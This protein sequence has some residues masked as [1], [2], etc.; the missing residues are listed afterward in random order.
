VKR[1]IDK[2]IE[3]SKLK[4]QNTNNNENT[5]SKV[6]AT[7]ENAINFLTYEDKVQISFEFENTVINVLK[8]KL[9]RAAKIM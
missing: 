5:S 2:R 4:T 9:F 3:N 6:S 7:R 1:E 8:D